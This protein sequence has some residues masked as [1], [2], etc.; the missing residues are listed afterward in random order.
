MATA[1]SYLY[2]MDTDWV[3]TIEYKITSHGA[4]ATYWDPAEDVEWDIEKIWISQDLGRKIVCPEFELTGAM[5]D[6]VADLPVVKTTSC[7]MSTIA[8]TMMSQTMMTTASVNMSATII[9]GQ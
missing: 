6:L 2:M 9:L 8:A 1:T 4:A 3:V 5:F 7:S